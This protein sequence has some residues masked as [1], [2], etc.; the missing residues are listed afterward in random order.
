MQTFN[1]MNFGNTP[2]FFFSFDFPV[3]LF[4]H[5]APINRVT[6]IGY[7]IHMWIP[8]KNVKFFIAATSNCLKITKNFNS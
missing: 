4:P 6:F 1:F 2:G 3:K 7:L 8:E 5:L